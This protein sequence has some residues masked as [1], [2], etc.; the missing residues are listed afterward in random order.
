VR[1][2]NR[3]NK[4]QE[5]K[6]GCEPAGYF[7]EHIRRLGSENVF[8]HAAPERGAQALTFRALHQDHEDHEQGDEDVES[9]QDINQNGHRDGQYRQVRQFVNGGLG[10]GRAG[11]GAPQASRPPG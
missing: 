1:V 6:Q 8:G 3:K 9:K 10:G 5:K 2:K 11:T 4:S 7:R